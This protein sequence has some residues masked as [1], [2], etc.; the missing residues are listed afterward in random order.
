MKLVLATTSAHKLREMGELARAHGL[1][2]E[3]VGRGDFPGAPEVVE[4]GET[5]ADN[6]RKKAVALAAFTKLPALADDSGIC[7]D[8]LG[9]AP[10]VHSARWA[11][12]TDEDRTQALLEKLRG[13]APEKRAAHYACALCLA[14]P[15]GPTV[16]VEGR[17][18]GRIT[19]APRGQGGFGYDPVFELE[20][21]R[22]FAQVSAA[23]KNARSHRANAFALMA[24]HLRELAK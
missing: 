23:E 4:D 2:L 19:D 3:L 22:T 15:G 11:A 5:F 6:A 16:E 9:G 21:G 1:A 7:V 14:I 10:G 17:C 20:D 13:V 12:G 18:E 24:P 8:A